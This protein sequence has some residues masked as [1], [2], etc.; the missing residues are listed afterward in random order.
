MSRATA[1]ADR[2]PLA[3]PLAG[4][5]VLLVD[6][7]DG[8]G[9]TTY[10]RAVAA[11]AGAVYLHR[12]RPTMPCWECEHLEPVKA[13]L[14]YHSRKVVM[15]RG[16]I[17]N[18]VWAELFDDGD[19]ALFRE[20]GEYECCM[21]EFAR[22]GARAEII[23]RDPAAIRAEILGRGE[24]D[25]AAG[26]AVASLHRFERQVELTAPYLPTRVLDSD[27]VHAYLQEIS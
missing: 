6:G 2:R 18:P 27:A 3:D 19:Q 23:V 1:A 10:A 5:T 25:R 8:V 15:D 17:G 13:V 22:L 26:V 24:S 7:P 11:R 9:K 14:R 12:A 21:R 16:P 20:P 4:Y